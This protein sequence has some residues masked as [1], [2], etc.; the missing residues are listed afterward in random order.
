M[1][2]SPEG[3][4]RKFTLSSGRPSLQCVASAT[5]P[6]YER[7]YKESGGKDLQLPRTTR[8]SPEPR[9]AQTRDRRCALS[10]FRK[11]SA[12]WSPPIAGL[13]NGVI[14]L[15]LELTIPLRV[16]RPASEDQPTDGKHHE[17]EG[18]P[19]QTNRGFSYGG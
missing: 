7:A 6:K 19:R 15:G 4:S 12:G 14:H 10:L 11:I 17:P 8:F 18:E 3:L 2:A 5:T 1:P 16:A 13:I 9:H